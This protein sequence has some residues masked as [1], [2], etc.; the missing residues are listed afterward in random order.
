MTIITGGHRYYDPLHDVSALVD[1]HIWLMAFVWLVAA[2]L[3]I[4]IALYGRLYNKSWWG[5]GHMAIMGTI[6]TVPL[7]IGVAAG[8]IAVKGIRMRSHL[9]KIIL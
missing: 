3:A 9:V 6:V 4:G 7:I 2:P 1:M 8:F 5:N